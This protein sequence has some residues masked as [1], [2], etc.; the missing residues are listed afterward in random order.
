MDRSGLEVLAEQA[1]RDAAARFVLPSAED[2]VRTIRVRV[3]LLDEATRRPIA[4]MESVR[5]EYVLTARALIERA[6]AGAYRGRLRRT[7][8][9]ARMEE[10]RGP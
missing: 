10:G 3:R 2:F 4:A 7:R 1:R 5:G 6:E 8:F 9:V